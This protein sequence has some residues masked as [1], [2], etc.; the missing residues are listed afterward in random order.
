MPKLLKVK[1][2]AEYLGVP[3]SVIREGMRAQ[4]G[5]P[6]HLRH[7]RLGKAFYTTREWLDEW[8]ERVASEPPASVLRLDRRAE[9]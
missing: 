7:V 2:A 5:R 4:P 6:T 8:V 1:E 3:E 9:G